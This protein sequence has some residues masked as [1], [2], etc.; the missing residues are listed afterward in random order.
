ML[1]FMLFI[2]TIVTALGIA[3]LAEPDFFNWLFDWLEL[4]EAQ[5][6][7][8]ITGV[9]GTTVMAWGTR[10]LRTTVN[11]DNLKRDA[12]HQLEIRK[13]EDR[14]EAE[15]A[16]LKSDFAQ[17]I[18]VQAESTNEI[19][20]T[21]NIVIEQNKLLIS[22][23]EANAERMISMND[24]LVPKDVKESYSNFLVSS[25]KTPKIDTLKHYYVE[26]V[27][28]VKEI[29]KPVTSEITRGISE[30]INGKGV[31]NV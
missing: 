7:Y 14:H 31:S 19:I 2:S 25:R 12:L 30:R 26:N 27:E 8:F 24:T 15:M 5:R 23:R 22:E 3:Y 17:A 29:L 28:I 1:M 6:A 4:T 18:K 16:L 13:I 9:G 11:T 10:I 21:L 20:A